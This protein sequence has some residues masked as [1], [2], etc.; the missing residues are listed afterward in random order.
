MTEILL[1]A[2]RICLAILKRKRNSR[3]DFMNSGFELAGCSKRELLYRV[4]SESFP[5]FLSPDDYWRLRDSMVCFL[6]V[7]KQQV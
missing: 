6:D 5:S 7:K 1:L 4:W 2:L 3:S